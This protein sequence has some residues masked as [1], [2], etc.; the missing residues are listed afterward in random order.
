[1]DNFYNKK[2]VC[3]TGIPSYGNEYE[4]Q[5]KEKACIWNI[6]SQSIPTALGT[7]IDA[8]FLTQTK[9]LDKAKAES[10]FTHLQSKKLVKKHRITKSQE[11][12]NKLEFSSIYANQKTKDDML[13]YLNNK[14]SR[15]GA[16]PKGD[17]E[18]NT[19]SYELRS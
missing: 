2:K 8:E 1:M 10:L 13:K 6:F 16:N 12:I 4:R 9:F 14:R 18:E 5:L 7:T 15:R 19:F 3:E 11:K 17:L